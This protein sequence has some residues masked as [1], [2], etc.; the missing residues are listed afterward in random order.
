MRQSPHA[1]KF[2]VAQYRAIFKK[3]Y[4]KGLASSLCLAGLLGFSVQAQANDFLRPDGLESDAWQDFK[5]YTFSQ[6]HLYSPSSNSLATIQLRQSIV[7]DSN[8]TLTDLYGSNLNLDLTVNA[9]NGNK[10]A[11]TISLEDDPNTSDINEGLLNI[12]QGQIVLSSGDASLEIEKGR[13]EIFGDTLL[14]AKDGVD[15]YSYPTIY[16]RP[17]ATLAISEPILYRFLTNLDPSGS[18]FYPD[19]F[20]GRVV[21]DADATLDF[22][23]LGQVDLVKF[24]EKIPIMGNTGAVVNYKDS[25]SFLFDKVIIPTY[26][27]NMLLNSSI[28]AHE[29]TLGS[30]DIASSGMPVPFT[31]NFIADQINFVDKKGILDI[32]GNFQF[33]R[34]YYINSNNLAVNFPG[35]INGNVR[36]FGASISFGSGSWEYTGNLEFFAGKSYLDLY[37]YTAPTSLKITGNLD[38]VTG[39]ISLNAQSSNKATLDLTQS[40]FTVEEGSINLEGK[41]DSEIYDPFLNIDDIL[42]QQTSY[43]HLIINKDIFETVLSTGI[44]IGDSIVKSDFGGVISIKNHDG[45]PVQFIADD[46][47]E[48]FNFREG[49]LDFQGDLDVIVKEDEFDLQYSILAA[50]S[51]NLK[52]YVDYDQDPNTIIAQSSIIDNTDVHLDKGLTIANNELWLTD[53]RLV[54][55]GRGGQILIGFDDATPKKLSFYDGTTS[56]VIIKSGDWTSNAIFDVEQ[57]I[58]LDPDSNHPNYSFLNIGT[59]STVAS[60]VSSGFDSSKTK[61]QNVLSIAKGSNATFDTVNFGSNNV[62]IDNGVLTIKGLTNASDF[63]TTGGVNLAGANISLQGADAKFILGQN[64]LDKSVTTSGAKVSF[65]QA[66]KGDFKLMDGAEITFDF[67]DQVVFDSISDFVDNLWFDFSD[68]FINLGNAQICPDLV[69]DGEI[70]H[71]D[72]ETILDNNIISNITSNDLKNAVITEVTNASDIKGS[73]GAIRVDK[74]EDPSFEGLVIDLSDNTSLSNAANN[75]GYFVSNSSQTQ[76]G[77]VQVNPDK[78]LILNGGGK[79]G[80][81][82]VKGNNSGDSKDTFVTFNGGDGAL[83]EVSDLIGSG[84]HTFNFDV[85]TNI[86]GTVDANVVNVNAKVTVTKKFEVDE[87]NLK[88]GS[89]SITSEDDFVANGLVNIGADTSFNVF[90]VDATASNADLMVSGGNVNIKNKLNSGLCLYSG[91]ATVKDIDAIKPIIV[92]NRKVDGNYIDPQLNI[93]GV[94]S[95]EVTNSLTLKGQEFRA[96]APDLGMSKVAINGFSSLNSSSTLNKFKAGYLDGNVFVGKN[97]RM[98][99]G[100]SL[101]EL[102]SKV[103]TLNNSCIDSEVKTVFYVNKDF[104]INQGTGIGLVGAGEYNALKHSNNTKYTDFAD[105][106]YISKDTVLA[107]NVDS[108]NVAT[109]QQSF[110]R[111]NQFGDAVITF[112]SPNAK[113]IAETGGYIVLDGNVVADQPYNLFALDG[114]GSVKVEN[115]DN[116]VVQDWEG[117]AVRTANGLLTGIVKDSLSNQVILSVSKDYNEVFA[118]NSQ[119]VKE[120]LIKYATQ[121]SDLSQ[122]GKQ[123]FDPENPSKVFTNSLLDAASQ[124]NGNAAEVASRF[125]VYG[126]AFQAAKLASESTLDLINSRM[127]IGTQSSSMNIAPNLNGGALWVAGVYKNQDA[128]GFDAQDIQYGAEV[129]LQGLALGGDFTLDNGPTIGVMFNIG[130]GDSQGKGS[131]QNVNNDFD[132][133]SF[134][135]YS[136]YKIG[137]FDLL[138]DLSFTRIS[139]DISANTDADKITGDFDS[140]AFSVGVTT[141]Y[142]FDFDGV[143]VKPHIGARYNQLRID[144]YLIRGKDPIANYNAEDVSYFSVPAGITISSDFVFDNWTIEPS[145]DFNVAFNFRADTADGEVVWEGVPLVTAVQSEIM[146]SSSYGINLGLSASNQA[147]TFGLGV[148]YAGS[149]NTNTYGVQA[150]FKY[151]F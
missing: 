146:D 116:T 93:D 94:G 79:V 85:D 57:D 89:F 122:P 69:L 55:G 34:P 141:Q 6:K 48:V 87:F 66:L 40:N 82:I 9:S 42:N 135:V 121:D 83:T 139:N 101:A 81:I 37:A 148:A 25:S 130:T 131:S 24:T 41:F 99:V 151:A 73:I 27:Q 63:G 56:A 36:L 12:T 28:Y 97:V 114:G 137:G 109:T 126:G 86:A 71:T 49:I 29:I 7:V 138:G 39:F 134:A 46:F 52:T 2:L 67:S 78:F 106:I 150:N 19:Y 15:Y 72:Y 115:G 128:D 110:A 64:I 95:L 23:H 20:E 44:R 75:N 38:L 10:V 17:N 13:V 145:V 120:T 136:S 4:F 105:K 61:D 22:S 140:Q 112:E 123:P 113:L 31:N 11:A 88:S 59:D 62:Y 108:T 102:N 107:I 16:V 132:Y 30:K 5:S 84:K 103:E 65:D 32:T 51:L 50:D 33:K 45:K 58:T 60:F 100:L 21:L 124:G 26:L 117:V 92:G 104:R 96:E 127:G 90:N 1:L 54:F 149:E 147:F 91:N 142:S 125:G 76:A 118:S 133:Y 77:N 18:S 14:L 47:Y 129:D 35:L 70:S 98:G 43:S 80:D 3:A 111:A 53:S 144:D 143:V 74:S 119:P 8:Q 68:G